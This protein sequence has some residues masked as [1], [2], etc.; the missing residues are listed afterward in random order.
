[1]PYIDTYTRVTRRATFGEETERKT[2]KLLGQLRCQEIEYFKWKPRNFNLD[3]LL[4]NVKIDA[5]KV[6]FLVTV[7]IPLRDAEG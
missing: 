6:T 1:M 7:G 3:A 2:G 4:I 5:G